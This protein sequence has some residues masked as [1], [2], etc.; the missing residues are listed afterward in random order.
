MRATGILMAVIAI[1]FVPT[2]SSADQAQPLPAQPLPAQQ[3]AEN[4]APPAAT[5]QAAA[6]SAVASSTVDQDEV[7]C[8]RTVAPTT[9]T[10]FGGARECHTVREWKLL[11]TQK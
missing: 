10:R 7:V 2:V 6:P 1:L 8:R 11:E 4:P 3:Q 9:G 5:G